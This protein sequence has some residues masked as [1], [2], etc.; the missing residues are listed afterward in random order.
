MTLSSSACEMLL[1]LK[2]RFQILQEQLASTIFSAI[3]KDLAKALN[4]F[5]YDEVGNFLYNRFWQ[6]HRQ[7]IYQTLNLIGF[8]C[9]KTFPKSTFEVNLLEQV[10][11]C[12][13]WILWYLDKLKIK[14]FFLLRTISGVLQGLYFHRLSWSV[15]SMKEVQRSYSLTSQRIF[16]HYFWNTHRNQRISLKSKLLKAWP[17]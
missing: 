12:A 11:V 4:K 16:S 17:S 14:V 7:T 10:M 6:N 13:Q 8:F 5:I 3:W 15:I 9:S 1:F 2:G